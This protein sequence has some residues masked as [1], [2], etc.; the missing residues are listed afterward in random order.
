M[1]NGK[2]FMAKFLITITNISHIR[3][4]HN[5]HFIGKK[6]VEGSGTSGGVTMGG[7]TT[8]YSLGK[9]PSSHDISN[10]KGTGYVFSR[11]NGTVYI[12]NKSDVVATIPQK[13]FVEPKK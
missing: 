4:F 7:S 3:T 1:S 11:S 10:A 13:R 6:I 2:E 8:T 9:A 5:Y 12:F